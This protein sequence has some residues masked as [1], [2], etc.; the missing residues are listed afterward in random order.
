MPNKYPKKKGWN[1]P[2]QKHK[3]QNWPDY[4]D[5]LRQRGA[6]EIWISAEAINNWYEPNRVYDRSEERRVGKECRIIRCH[7]VRKENKLP[8]RQCEGFIKTI[9]NLMNLDITVPE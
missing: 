7:E 5:A 6:I 9:F 4:N 2:K 1:V 8:L 3:L